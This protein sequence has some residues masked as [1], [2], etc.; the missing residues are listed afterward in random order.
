MPGIGL[1]LQEYNRR[2]FD[3]YRVPAVVDV[4]VSLD[5]LNPTFLSVGFSTPY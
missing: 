3:P 1:I 5:I 2:G 4:V